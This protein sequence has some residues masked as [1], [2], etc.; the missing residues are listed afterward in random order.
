[1]RLDAGTQGWK[2][3]SLDRYVYTCLHYSDVTDIYRVDTDDAGYLR[4]EQPL[5]LVKV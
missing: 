4:I 5:L 1:M 2:R 3:I